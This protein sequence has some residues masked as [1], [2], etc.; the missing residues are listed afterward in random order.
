MSDPQ[1]I[2]RLTGRVAI[3]DAD[4]SVFRVGGRQAQTLLAMLALEGGSV[5]TEYVADVLW[6]DHLSQ[7][8][9]GALRGVVSKLRN[10]LAPLTTVER[11]LV[12]ADG[13]IRAEIPLTSNVDRVESLIA[14][15]EH[16]RLGDERIDELRVLTAE[17]HHPFLIHDDSTWADG[18]RRRIEALAWHAQHVV[19]DQLWGDDRITEATA[20][21]EQV[22]ARDPM[23]VSVRETLTRLHLGAGELSAARRSFDEL[24]R[25][26][27]T[28]FGRRPDADLARQVHERRPHRLNLVGL[29]V[30]R[31]HPDAAEPFIGREPAMAV[32]TE[33]WSR[34]RRSEQPELVLVR[35]P[36]GIGKTRLADHAL[37]VLDPPQR[38]WGRA[39]PAGGHT[40]GPFADALADVFVE[41]T[42]L[43]HIASAE[44]PSIDRL[45]PGLEPPGG[46]GPQRGTGEDG[47][48][49]TVLSVARQII[50]DLLVEPTILVLDDLQWTGADG[51]ALIESVLTDSSGPLLVIATCREV[52]DAV[53]A[54]LAGVARHRRVTEVPLESFDLGELTRLARDHDPGDVFTAE[55]IA[56]MHHR[57]GGLPY[58]ACAL[59]RDA[60]IKGIDS[61]D[62]SVPESVSAWLDNFLRTITDQKRRM[63]EVVA[64][65]GTDADLAA[66][67]A[68][69]GS[70]SI[71]VADTIDALVEDGLVTVTQ[72][73]DLRIAHDLTARAVWTATGSARRAVLHRLAGDHLVERN[74][75]P[76]TVAGHWSLAGP[77]RHDQAVRAHL[78]AGESSLDQG[79]WRAAS[80]HFDRAGDGATDATTRIAALIGSGRAL[81]HLREHDRAR[82][83]LEHALELATHHGEDH[84]MAEATLLLVGRAGRGA[85]LGD[86]AA[87]LARLRAAHQR[88][89]ARERT[90]DDP[91]TRILLADVERELAISLLFVAGLPER[92]RLLTSAL[93]RVRSTPEATTN[94]LALALLGQ[95]MAR[96]DPGEL[97]TRIAEL[98]EV[99]A[100]P[101]GRLQA[102]ALISAHLYRHEDLIRIGRRDEALGDL[103]MARQIADATHHAYWSWAVTTWEALGLLLDGSLS[104]AEIRFATAA[105][106][107]PGVGEAIA[108]HQVNLITLRL[109]QG[110]G[111][112][113]L[114]S[115]Q[116]AVRDYPDIPTWRAALALTAAEAGEFGV[117]EQMLG[118][119]VDSDFRDLPE[120]TNRFFALGILAH[121]AATLGS[122]RAAASLWKL[123]EPYR[124]HLVL[125]NVYGG[126]G[127]YW[128]PVEW[129]LARLGAL[130]DHP[131]GQV[132]ALWDTAVDRSRVVPVLIG[133]ITREAED[134]EAALTNGSAGRTGRSVSTSGS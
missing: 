115:L 81:V 110:R 35:G 48:R 61:D 54:V 26:L 96:I 73:G 77:S 56:V 18:Q 8:W 72:R 109:M 55:D 66:V 45:L 124:G 74:A 42:S 87:Q 84:A 75:P 106:A 11:P 101:H 100:L 97:N 69:L 40:W 79:A 43:A 58:F 15:G 68:V 99:L 120:D 117:A 16:G 39:R 65:F 31:H 34:V 108:C 83:I 111:M 19:L 13:T 116:A 20:W 46:S 93:E 6:G 128:G 60:R 86:E 102:D 90:D 113:M 30:I 14:D 4:G 134:A 130:L 1:I 91:R 98:D 62:A 28:E 103:V 10:T 52:P 9:R 32:I 25:V 76:A 70:G 78:R 41:N 114:E 95:R 129:A 121:V 126:G 17:L 33:A 119:F 29:P 85:I 5:S 23:D 50:Q 64:V 105:D 53:A 12:S 7:H 71:D 59:L 57:T 22:I 107:R 123:L 49:E 37:G 125:L 94:D 51:L 38:L 92:R 67:E 122:P 3:V 24:E 88:L 80:D 112:E 133:R 127:A 47:A 44:F 36:A 132:L 2:I 27:A 21:A 63:L 118:S 131:V 89:S 104:A 82:E